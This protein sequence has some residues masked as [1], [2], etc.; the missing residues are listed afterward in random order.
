MREAAQKFPA[1]KHSLLYV[2][3]ARVPPEDVLL[4]IVRTAERENARHGLSG[5]LCY[6]S[7]RYL[8]LLDGPRAAL[9]GL[10]SGLSRDPRHRVLW[11]HR[12]PCIGRPI[13]TDLPMG[14][15]S[16]TQLRELGIRLDFPDDAQAAVAL[17]RALVALAVRIYPTACGADA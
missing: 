6:S 7:T 17:A 5:M 11:V 9:D 12:A 3:V 10:W 15:A 2:S 1:D 14:Y 8:Q 13:P 16:T 4:D